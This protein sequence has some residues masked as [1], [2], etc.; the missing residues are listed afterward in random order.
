M[1]G[2]LLVWTKMP[3]G[4][5]ERPKATPI[6]AKV[7][8]NENRNRGQPLFYIILNTGCKGKFCWW[9]EIIG[10]KFLQ[11]YL[12]LFTIQCKLSTPCIFLVFVYFFSCLYTF[13]VVCLQLQLFVYSFCCLFIFQLF[14][15]IHF[16]L[17]VYSFSCLFTVFVVC[18]QFQLF[19]YIS[20]AVSSFSC[21]FTFLAVC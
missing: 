5:V 13:S 19:V 14:V 7:W 17:F 21:V 20:N 2:N 4:L 11:K 18:F 9:N 8:V 12:T 15:C 3:L 10:P 6:S 16:P 1:Q